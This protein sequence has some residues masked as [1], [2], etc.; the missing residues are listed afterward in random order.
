MYAQS[1]ERMLNLLEAEL[2]VLVRRP[3]RVLGTELKRQQILVTTVSYSLGWACSWRY[4]STSVTHFNFWPS[5]LY[6]STAAFI[7]VCYHIW[8]FFFS[9]FFFFNLDAKVAWKWTLKT[10]N[11]AEAKSLIISF[12]QRAWSSLPSLFSL[13][14]CFCFFVFLRIIYLF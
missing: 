8:L 11:R 5:L 9:F 6:L 3:V 4:P 1:R 7:G 10:Q 12:I 2:Q 14:F 13:C